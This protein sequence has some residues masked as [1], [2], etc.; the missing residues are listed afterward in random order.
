MSVQEA[1]RPL[2]NLA[3]RVPSSEVHLDSQ[4]WGGERVR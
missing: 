1:Q 2:L 4:G 3:S